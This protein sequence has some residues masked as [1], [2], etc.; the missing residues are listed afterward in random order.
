MLS[1]PKTYEDWKDFFTKRLVE[2]GAFRLSETFCK[3][4]TDIE[5]YAALRENPET[6]IEVGYL[7]RMTLIYIQISNPSTPGKNRQQ[8]MEHLYKYQF[9]KEKQ[10]GPP[11][12][13]FNELNVQGI[14]DYLGQGFNGKEIVYYRRGK[15]VKSKLT[16][17]YYPDSPQSTITFDFD[18]ESLFKRL[19]NK[20]FKGQE[21]YDEVKT[22]DLQNVFG[23][24]DSS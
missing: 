24:L 1:S 13:D 18:E 21:K 19:F 12:L 11:G 14:S 7:S 9:D 20:I 23:G 15:P 4:D 22:I 17:S 2:A 16:T 3:G 10:Y 8:E 5:I 6:T